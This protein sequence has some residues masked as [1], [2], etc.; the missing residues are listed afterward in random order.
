MKL[1]NFLVDK[2]PSPDA[3]PEGATEFHRHGTREN[4]AYF[5][6][7]GGGQFGDAVI[8]PDSVTFHGDGDG[9]TITK[10]QYNW[11]VSAY[12]HFSFDDGCRMLMKWI[13]TNAN[14]HS[15][16]IID[17]TSAVLYSGEKSIHTEE[18]IKD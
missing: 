14:P 5:Y 7:A 6:G 11:W 12:N 15:V 16:I 3:W 8:L 1:I 17:A 2:F 10:E 9:Q 4:V 18:F 13:N